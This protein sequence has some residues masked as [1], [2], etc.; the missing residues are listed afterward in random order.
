MKN[1]IFTMVDSTKNKWFSFRFQD[2][3]YDLDV[4]DSIIG[5]RL[6]GSV[7]FGG[8]A[9]KPKKGAS[10]PTKNVLID[11]VLEFNL[12]KRELLI[13]PS[14]ATIDGRAFFLKGNFEFSDTSHMHLEIDA[15]AI[16]SAEANTIV[17]QHIADKLNAFQFENPL[18]AAIFI[19]GYLYYGSK[20][21][22]DVFFKT[23]KNSITMK[24][25]TFYDVSLLGWFQNHADSTRINDDENS[26]VM[27]PRFYREPGRHSSF[28]KTNDYQLVR[29]E[30]ADGCF[31]RYGINRCRK[32][33]GQHADELWA[34]NAPA[35]LQL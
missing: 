1:V 6:S 9:F 2:V 18:M 8:L 32:P 4:R 28:L 22:V 7:Y 5:G 25:K 27:I 33:C 35:D 24:T 21:S 19:D 13:S 34:G 31:R 12:N 30:S 17:T 26:R 14:K 16:T 20:P 23:D 29:S 15:P 10:S 3:D 11:L